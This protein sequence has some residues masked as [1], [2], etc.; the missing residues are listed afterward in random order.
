MYLADKI[1]IGEVKPLSD[2]SVAVRARVARAGIY[3]YLASEIGAPDSFRPDQVVKVYRPKDEV[4]SVKSVAS[5]IGKPVTDDHPNVPV[6]PANY[7]DHARGAVMGALPDGEYLAFDM[8]LLDAGIIE[9]VNGGKRELSNGYSCTL[10]W[11]PGKTDGGQ[12]YDAVQRE[13]RGNHVAVVDQARAGSKCRIGDSFQFAVCDSI[14][15]TGD[16]QVNTKTITVDGLQVLVTDAAEAAII[17]L[18]GQIADGAKVKCELDVKIASLM[19]DVA[20]RDGKIAELETKL[21]DSAITPAKLRDAAA[22]YARTVEIGKALGVAVSDAMDEAAIQK[23][24]VSKVVGDASNGWSAAEIASSFVS[25]SASVKTTDALTNVIKDGVKSTNATT[26][27]L[28]AEAKARAGWEK[29]ITTEYK[30]AA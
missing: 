13:I 5:F 3:D 9:Q 12:S 8:L 22:S 11:T 4:F 15:L 20:T 7:R 28:D 6:T 16:R 1:S 26:A 27:L 19:T 10:D 21:A 23:A 24:A 2:G 18:Q 29:N 25:L 17:K 14:P 30:G